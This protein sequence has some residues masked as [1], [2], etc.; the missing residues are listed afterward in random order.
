MSNIGAPVEIEIGD[1]REAVTFGN[2]PWEPKTV[3]ASFLIEKPARE[4]RIHIP[5][6]TSP[7]IGSE[8]KI[9]IGLQRIS[10]HR[11]TD[12]RES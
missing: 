5:S 1:S 4:L 12:A 10:I 3:I 6:P 9:G 8:R 11:K 7:D 2:P